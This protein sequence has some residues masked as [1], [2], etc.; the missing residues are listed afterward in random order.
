[1]ATI[2]ASPLAR[3]FPRSVALGVLLVVVTAL[4]GSARLH[5]ATPPD[6]TDTLVASVAAPTAL[7]FTPDGRLL[8]TTQ[9]GRLR[10]YANG[11]LRTTAALDIGTSL[12]TTSEQGMLGVAVDPA[13]TTNRTI[14]L[15][16]TRLSGSGCVNRVSSFVLS[17]TNT[18]DPASETVLVDNIPA[19]GGNHNAGDLQFGKDGYL[20]VSVGDGGCD[21]NDD[22][23]CAHENDAAR[24]QHI[25]LGKILRI[26]R[27]GSIPPTNPY[28]GTDSARCNLTGR[29]D[30]GKKCQETFAWGL[31]NP[32]RIAFDPDAA[33]TEF[34]INDV[35]QSTWEEIDRG[36]AG[37]DYG[38]NV[39]EG[40]CERSSETRCGAPP[41]GMTNPIFA[42]GRDEGCRSITGGAFIP[43]G[44]WPSEYDGAY[45]YADYVCGRIFKLVPSGSS[46]TS[47]EFATGLGGSGPVHL[48]FGPHGSTRALYYTNYA[49]GGQIRRIAYTGSA[50]RFP[51]AVLTA[52]PTSGEPPL[53][54]NFDGTGSSDPDP[55]TT[56]SYRWSF[57]DGTPTVDTATPTV[58]HT[59]AA[60]GTYT[61]MLTVTDQQ[62]ASSPPA[63][64]RIDAGNTPPQPTIE[65][66]AEGQLFRVG[67]TVTLHGTASDAQD[68]PLPAARLTWEVIL[69]HADHTHP[70]LQPTQ[71]NDVTITAPLPEDLAAA[72][73]SYLEVKLTAID[74]HGLERTV[75]REF[76]PRK[77]DVTF[78][79]QPPGL[80]LTVSATPV[81]GPQ[82]VVSWDA[83]R[84]NVD[85]RAQLDQVG[86]Y[87][88][89]ES[90]SDG[91]AA[92]HSITVPATAATYTATFV[93][94]AA[95]TPGL[96]AAYGFNEGSGSTLE[97]LSG[98]GNRGTL[99][100]PTWADAGRFGGALSFDGINDTVDVADAD[101][102]DLTSAL[103]LEA[104][105]KT[106][107]GS[108][109]RTV[110]L[111][112]RPGDLAY[113]L[114]ARF[115]NG[116][117]AGQVDFAAST[118][119]AQGSALV[120]ADTWT[121][122]ATTY[123]GSNLRL[124]VNG[125]LAATTAATGGVVTSASP[126]RIGGNAIWG[127][128]LG[129]VID[130]VRVY[131]R[132]LSQAEIQEDMNSPVT[133]PDAT[134]PQTTVESGPSGVTPLAPTRFAFSA[135]EEAVFECRLD[136]GAWQA[137]T[138]PISYP[139]TPGPHS[140][141]VR[142]TDGAGNVD[143]SPATRSFRVVRPF[144]A[145][146]NGDSR[147]D[148]AVWRPADG[149]WYALDSPWHQ[150]GA[151]GDVPVPGNWDA[152]PATDIA[153]WRPSNG[154]WYVQGGPWV[155]W[156]AAED[157]PVPADYN[158]DGSTDIAVW[159]PS[160]GVW[161]VLGVGEWQWGAAGDVP[162]PG[163]Y[164]GDGR[165]E[166]A[167]WRPSSGT[168]YVLGRPEVDWGREGDVPVPAD[169]HGDGRAEVAVWRP[170]DGIWWVLGG[171][172]TQW[173]ADG[174]VP[175]PGDYDGNGDAEPTVFRPATGVWYRIGGPWPQWGADG[176]IP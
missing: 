104:W 174:D 27:D 164:N 11:A 57:G 142:A 122:L 23:G 12:C 20:Y 74:S 14:Y 89:F 25:L 134:P 15:Y 24:D 29:T 162:V 71:G 119:K 43:N 146:L 60:A 125:T 143:P 35:G 47:S 13:F 151:A 65:T 115:S 103:T 30:P 167:V 6:F 51:T 75:T 108:S 105:V 86:T 44:I 50:N 34:F 40:F 107:G 68:G 91:G 32:F 116:G 33:G 45:L 101:S 53:T 76:Q 49:N 98:N 59:Y 54:V 170:S 175:V 95:P 81:T 69:H 130:E 171:A 19:T 77:V 31:R 100:G 78:A 139:A 111:K 73:N 140:F 158:G 48:V 17:D 121:H 135:D 153:V 39:R 96:V 120:P 131:N 145:D 21:Y 84:L 46:Y 28:R 138:S 118:A 154:V 52:S 163:D 172:A 82:T 61:A 83:A 90:W 157:V 155:Q 93:R 55:G 16:M 152:D 63:Q 80:S 7:A 159:R 110:V 99:A 144:A 168:W 106:T 97:D 36:E 137:C 160:T 2:P 147:A 165:A 88:R 169:Y 85:A 10:I 41:A 56:L 70:F 58:S 148:F 136:S 127:E 4:A 161:Y 72:T 166:V 112:E 37:A 113:A 128:Y 133:A 149:I 129:G 176:D 38:W 92:A 150:W 1:M 66:P 62:G 141:E 124:Y 114:Y 5:A 79:T 8:I 132:A 94:G 26:A 102:L 64:L 67:E 173:G 156:G 109:W 18:V 22:S 3:R 42:Y 117:P 123:D 9:P 126:L 87:W